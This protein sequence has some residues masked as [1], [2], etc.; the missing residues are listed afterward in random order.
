M[1]E[2]TSTWVGEDRRKKQWHLDRRVPIALILAVLAQTAGVFW[3]ASNIQTR[4]EALE[5]SVDRTATFSERL[6]SIEKGQQ[7]IRQD[8]NDLRSAILKEAR[9]R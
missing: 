5:R 9:G 6:G 7:F 1:P 4:M 2:D 8:L 3:W